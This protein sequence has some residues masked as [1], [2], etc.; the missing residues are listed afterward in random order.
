MGDR[1]AAALWQTQTSS[2]QVI[3]LFLLQVYCC[4]AQPS[5]KFYSPPS[6]PKLLDHYS[7]SNCSSLFSSVTDCFGLFNFVMNCLGIVL[8]NNESFL[9]CLSILLN[10]GCLPYKR[11]RFVFLKNGTIMLYCHVT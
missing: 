2:I 3:P 7:V 11:K 10:R 4:D 8:F 9:H 5:I 1:A 6:C